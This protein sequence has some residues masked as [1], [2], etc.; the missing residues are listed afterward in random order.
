MTKH[1]FSILLLALSC[2]I[3]FA[4]AKLEG[5]VEDADTGEPIV[6]GTV[7]L[8]QNGV[9]VTGS[10]TDFDGYYSLTEIAQGSYELQF[11]TAGYEPSIVKAFHI[12]EGKANKLDM[13]MHVKDEITWICCCC[14]RPPI[15]EQDNTTQGHVF[16]MEDI[17]HSPFR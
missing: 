8:F 12:V 17:R 13:T 7:A 9:L 16:R 11:L 5:I 6:Y 2:Q 1:L 14:Y 3:S 10:E 15:V 4:Q